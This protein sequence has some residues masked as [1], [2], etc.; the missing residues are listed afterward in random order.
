M[1]ATPETVAIALPPP[2]MIPSYLKE[3]YWWAYVHPHAVKLFERQWLVNFILLGNFSRLRD[4][5]LDALGE[6]LEGRTL[7]IA[8]V[9]G[10]FSQRIAA[11]LAPQAELDVIDVLPIQLENLREKLPAGARVNALLRDSAA[12]GFDDHSYDQTVLFFLLHEQPVSVR[13]RTLREAIRVTRPGGKV[14]IV[15][16]HQPVWSNPFRYLLW[17][18]LNWLEPFAMDLWQRDITAWLPPEI[19]PSQIRTTL[20]FGGLYQQVEITLQ[21]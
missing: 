8:C 1:S 14:V 6:K 3:V 15:D 7:Q 4:A 16:Y 18:V 13:T 19:K 11:R 20:S 9:Y 2:A 12:L 10:D 5:A 17:P 21:D